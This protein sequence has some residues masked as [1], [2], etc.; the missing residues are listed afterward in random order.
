MTTKFEATPAWQR[1]WLLAAAIY[2]LLWG[3]ATVLWPSLFFEGLGLEP[4]NYAPIWQCLGMVIGVYGVGYWI[5]AFD[6]VRHWSIVFVG[7][8]GKLLGPIGFVAAVWYESLPLQFG[9]GILPNDVLWWI[10]FAL[11][12]KHA[13]RQD[14]LASPLKYVRQISLRAT[15]E[16]VFQFHERP[17]ALP[18]L[19]PP[20][21]NTHPVESSG[22]LLPGSRVVL[23]GRVG[24]I[25]VRW[26]AVHTEY[27]PP[28]LFADYQES[29]PFV[30]WYHRHRIIPDEHG[31][32]ILSDEVEY[33]LPLGPI[34]RW[35]GQRF[36]KRK[37]DAMFAYRHEVTRKHVE[38]AD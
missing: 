4:I 20:W 38:G 15:P 35:L 8:L 34:G 3:T 32:S 31:G 25:P 30:V 13:W 27:E 14:A 5:A 6:P 16:A 19:I 22:S 24:M 7:L 26:V 17:D 1:R 21:E 33:A 11:I 28:Y 37:L 36:V 29:G 12:V 23:A 2:N 10:P 9:L 18:M